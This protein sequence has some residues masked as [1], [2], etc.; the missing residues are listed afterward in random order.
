MAEDLPWRDG[1]SVIIG[2]FLKED[3]SLKVFFAVDLTVGI[4]TL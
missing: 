1:S 2:I 4:T 3:A